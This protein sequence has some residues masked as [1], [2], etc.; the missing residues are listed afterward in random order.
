M[1]KADIKKQ[2]VS[3]SR[4][5]GMG[6]LRA[7]PSLFIAPAA[8]ARS[9]PLR[10]T[11]QSPCCTFRY[12]RIWMADGVAGG[13]H[14]WRVRRMG[15]APPTQSRHGGFVVVTRKT[16]R[17]GRRRGRIELRRTRYREADEPAV[18]FAGVPDTSRS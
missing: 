13:P 11:Y 1:C 16:A 7:R 3:I 4:D 15:P 5:A 9:G 10:Q 12:L 2:R 18:P 8:C 14:I 6:V 17:R